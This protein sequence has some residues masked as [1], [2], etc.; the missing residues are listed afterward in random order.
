MNF[1]DFSKAKISL[2]EY[3][4]EHSRRL[5]MAGWLLCLWEKIKQL[6]KRDERNSQITPRD[7]RQSKYK[8]PDRL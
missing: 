8:W 3:T 2:L 1:Y 5:K 6:V 4:I 7:V